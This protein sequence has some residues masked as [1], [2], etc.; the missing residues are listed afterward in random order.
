MQEIGC[1]ALNNINIIKKRHYHLLLVINWIVVSKK[2]R[3]A[4]SL[5]KLA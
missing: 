4:N 1:L 5:Y 3:S 2:G